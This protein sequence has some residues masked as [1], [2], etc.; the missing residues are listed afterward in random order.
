MPLAL[1]GILFTGFLF[2][3]SVYAQYQGGGVAD[4]GT[5]YVGE[6]LK[7]GDYFSYELCHVD[8]KECVDFQMD[9]W[10][11]GTITVGTEEKWLAQVVVYDGNKIVKG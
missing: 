4:D 5:W 6:G 3:P 2:I 1:I 7:Q 10:I 9:L 8:Y 11:E